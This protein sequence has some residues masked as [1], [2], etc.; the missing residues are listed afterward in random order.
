MD[1]DRTLVDVLQVIRSK[2]LNVYPHPQ[3][4][5]APATNANAARPTSKVGTTKNANKHSADLDLDAGPDFDRNE[6]AEFTC[7]LHAPKRLPPTGYLCHICY[8][9]GHYISDCPKVLFLEINK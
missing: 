8:D 4:V 7:L 9:Q 6:C 1:Y 5:A 2:P 3:A